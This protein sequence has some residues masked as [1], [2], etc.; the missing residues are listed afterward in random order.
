MLEKKRL[1]KTAYS[2]VHNCYVGITHAY[3][4]VDGS[5]IFVCSNS[6]NGI[7][8]VLHRESELTNFCL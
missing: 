4:D 3:C 6:S 1:Y 7:E 8:N 5:W 2:T